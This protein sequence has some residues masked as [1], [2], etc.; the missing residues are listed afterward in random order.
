MSYS[1]D[2]LKKSAFEDELNNVLNLVPSEYLDKDTV[3]V[4]EYF[5]RRIKELDAK[6]RI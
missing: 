1:I 2:A 3:S 4:I 5:K 6:T